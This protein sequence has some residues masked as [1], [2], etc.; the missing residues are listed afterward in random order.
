M[1]W[2][3]IDTLSP[4]L[5]YKHLPVVA[6][7]GYKAK[8]AKEKKE[9]EQA[10]QRPRTLREKRE[11]VEADRRK[12]GREAAA[13]MHEAEDEASASKRRFTHR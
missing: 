10:A 3:I 9:E 2:L 1:F 6:G 4:V 5:Q 11:Q 12:Y 7:L 13:K 8:E